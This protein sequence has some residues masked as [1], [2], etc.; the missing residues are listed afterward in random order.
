MS[1]LASQNT[2]G[3]SKGGQSLKNLNMSFT[4]AA[5]LA[6]LAK[7]ICSCSKGR[8]GFFHV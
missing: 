6:A 4:E 8:V 3:C 7:Q 2:E 5:D 1:V